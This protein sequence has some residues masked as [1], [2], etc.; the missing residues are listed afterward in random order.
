MQTPIV[1]EAPA[2]GKKYTLEL[3]MFIL[4][5]FSIDLLGTF[6]LFISLEAKRH[7]TSL[8]PPDAAYD[9]LLLALTYGPFILSPIVILV[10]I[11]KTLREKSI[12]LATNGRELILRPEGMR[13]S[14]AL[15]DSYT[16]VK[17]RGAGQAYLDIAW[18]EVAEFTIQRKHYKIDRRRGETIHVIRKHFR[19]RETE[20]L[21]WIEPKLSRP[22][23]KA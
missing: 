16:R 9:F 4:F 21:E 2:A 19:L 14:I 3:A 6:F 12:Y 15:I 22:T 13:I 7:G 18:E 17:L 1:F 5:G 10:G 11:R 8:F 20:L 23:V